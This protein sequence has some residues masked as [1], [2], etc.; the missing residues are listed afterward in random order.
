MAISG[1]DGSI[2]LTTKV[3]ESG[4]KKGMQQANKFAQMS[5][6]EQRRMAQSLSNVYRQQGMSQSEAQ[7]KAWH[8]LK[9]NTVATKDLA[10]ATEDVAKKTEQA[11]KETKEYGNTAKRSGTIAKKAF[12]TVGKAFLTIGVASAAAI[13]AMTKQAVSAYADYEQLVGGVETL[14]KGSA[15]RVMA[16]AENA[17]YTAGV[18][19]N[20]YM[21]QVTSF[22]A[23]LIRSTAGDTDKAADIANMALIDI[24]DNVNK[25]GSSMESVT[26]AYQGFAKQQYMLLDNLKLGYGGTKTEM[27]RLLKDAQALTGVKYDINNLADV[28]SAIHAIQEELGITGTTAKEAE[29]TITGSANMMKAAWKDVLSS[30]AGGGELDKAIQ[31]LTKSISIYFKNIVPVIEKALSGIGEVVSNIIPQLV[32]MLAKALIQALPQLVDAVFQIIVGI[33]Q[34]IFEGFISLFT[35]AENTTKKESE[36]IERTAESQNKLTGAIEETI[37]AQKKSLA[38]FDE[39]NTLQNSDISGLSISKEEISESLKGISGLKKEISNTTSETDKLASMWDSFFYEVVGET[40]VSSVVNLNNSILKLEKSVDSFSKS[41]LRLFA[42]IFGDVDLSQTVAGILSSEFD[43]TSGL[44]TMLSG[45]F[46]AATGIYDK[47]FKSAWEGIGKIIGGGMQYN[48]PLYEFF[49]GSEELREWFFPIHEDVVN[50]FQ[51]LT[52]EQARALDI[53]T[54]KYSD[55][56]SKLRETVYGF[57]ITDDD[58]SQSET[59]LENLSTMILSYAEKSRD[60]AVVALTD[61]ADKGLLSKNELKKGLKQIDDAYNKQKKAVKDNQ[62]GILSILE[63]ASSEKRKLTSEERQQIIGMLN[64]S[65]SEMIATIKTG[66]GDREKIEEELN[67]MSE[68]LAATHLSQVIQFANSEY[69]EKVDAAEKTH[70]ETVREANKAYYELGVINEDQYKDIVAKAEKTKKGEI[71]A[72]EESK[73]ELIKLA[74]EKAGEIAKTVDPETGEIYSKWEMLWSG[75]AETARTYLNKI[76]GFI[77]E[78]S[79]NGFGVNKAILEFLGIEVP[80]LKQIPELAKGAVIPPNHRF[81]AVLGDQ[82][83]GTNIEAPLDTIKQAVAEVLAQVNIGS[84]SNGRIEIPVIIDGR[85]VARAVREAENNM[86]SQTVFGGFAN[87]Y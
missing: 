52:T 80:E 31:K 26:L 69:Q 12:L 23:A 81:L 38:G 22:S 4:L 16:Y 56:A 9:N 1:G 34:G 30:I 64:E 11:T 17:F 29:K 63:K 87:V 10:K 50:L 45:G 19:A 46:D 15:K 76:I 48:I 47:D 21:K 61:L 24:S 75:M 43:I 51:G 82:K 13:V 83:H 67:T 70:Q 60:Q 37:D 66:A 55:I 3:D 58:V 20:E 71:K 74:Q 41:A 2:I 36:A 77:N 86:G 5:T 73:K 25:M 39:I 65:N 53:Y 85:E 72:A 84:G 59:L 62:S 57:N 7:K 79:I 8:D 32:R 27:E 42:S 18:S 33:A 49:G 68:Q 44:A 14:F 6:N 28:Y 54:S 35:E 78:F 40:S